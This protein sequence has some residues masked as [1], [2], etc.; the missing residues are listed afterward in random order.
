M[1]ASTLALPA[2][3]QFGLASRAPLRRLTVIVALLVLSSIE[4]GLPHGLVRIPAQAEQALKLTLLL[5]AFALAVR[6]N[7]RLRLVPGVPVLLAAT[8]LA[9]GAVV[10]VLAGVAGLDSLSRAARLCLLVL[11]VWLLSP[12]ALAEDGME[13]ARA[14]F[15]V[16]ALLTAVFLAQGVLF[17]GLAHEPPVGR[18]R[19]VLP[20]CD[21]PRVAEIAAV[22]AGVAVLLG[23]ARLLRPRTSLALFALGLVALLATHTRTALLALGLGLGI[24]LLSLFRESRRARIVLTSMVLASA[25]ALLLAWGPISAWLLRD[26]DEQQL[27]TLT[28]RRVV[29]AAI[30][31]A[32][33]PGLPRWF[34]IGL[35]QKK[36][37][38]LPFVDGWPASYR[39]PEKFP[40]N[41]R[42]GGFPVDS[43]WLASY[44]EQGY[45]GVGL[46]AGMLLATIVGALRLRPGPARAVAFFLAM[47]VAVS[48][49]TETGVS[50]ASPYLLHMTFAGLLVAGA[51]RAER[52]APVSRS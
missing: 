27:T 17:P 28:G 24:G 37:D 34:G 38:G 13:L 44:R 49:I 45:L 25:V 43:G 46:I 22:T 41:T 50:D 10:P 5:A 31:K 7:W 1:A 51:R 12:W 42:P 11:I 29:W 47:V 19:G 16:Y 15:S 14:Q 33:P 21:P 48:T 35:G 2:L 18:L 6:D 3:Q 52:R 40:Q 36:L 9:A 8:L 23:A 26:Q 39:L 20:A 4:W 30:P 32:Q